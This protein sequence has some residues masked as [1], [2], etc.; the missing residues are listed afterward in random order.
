MWPF[1]SDLFL[2]AYALRFILVQ[3]E[4]ILDFFL[5]LNDVSLHWYTV[6]Y[7]LRLSRLLIPDL[8]H[9]GVREPK[10]IGGEL[11]T[12]GGEEIKIHNLDAS[13]LNFYLL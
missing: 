9:C 8:F 1:V 5:R 6:F 12:Q 10:E 2:L 4:S 11:E 13:I 7:H 3:H